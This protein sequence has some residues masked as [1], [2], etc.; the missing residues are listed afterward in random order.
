[1]CPRSPAFGPA[2]NAERLRGHKA[3]VGGLIY[4]RGGPA[5]LART[6]S[7]LMALSGGALLAVAAL[8]AFGD[9]VEHDL[10]EGLGFLPLILGAFLFAEGFL[11]AWREARLAR[12][13]P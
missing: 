10:A 8:L 7:L 3:S 13:P 12:R 1:M 5:P 11:S 4:D 2:R 9:L 6:R